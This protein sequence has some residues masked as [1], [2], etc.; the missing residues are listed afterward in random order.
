MLT[1]TIREF[2][3]FLASLIL[4]LM[5]SAIAVYMVDAGMFYSLGFYT[6]SLS[7]A[8]WSFYITWSLGGDVYVPAVVIYRII[9]FG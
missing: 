4:A 8:D 2:G 6:I 9:F 5:A 7:G 1:I 3:G